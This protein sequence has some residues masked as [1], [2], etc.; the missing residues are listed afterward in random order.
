[1]LGQGGKIKNISIYFKIITSY[2]DI[3]TKWVKTS[4]RTSRTVC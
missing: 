2:V 3:V 4:I 1:M